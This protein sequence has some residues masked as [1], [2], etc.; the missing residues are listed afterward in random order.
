VVSRN[1]PHSLGNCAFRAW[2]SYPEGLLQ[3]KPS[4][5]QYRAHQSRVRSA[6]R[7]GSKSGVSRIASPSSC[8]EQTLRTVRPSVVGPSGQ[9]AIGKYTIVSGPLTVRMSVTETFSRSGESASVKG[10]P[11]GWSRKPCFR[12][13][14]VLRPSRGKPKDWSTKVCPRYSK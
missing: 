2:L 13:R 7:L 3:R 10:T 9:A 14:G 4:T 11:F 12:P 8:E 6:S 5:A 1:T